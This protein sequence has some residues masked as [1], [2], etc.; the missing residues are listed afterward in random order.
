MEMIPYF[1]QKTIIVSSLLKTVRM[2]D[3]KKHF[4]FC[5]I[6]KKISKKIDLTFALGVA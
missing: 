4:E 5:K 6:M 2:D 1:Y 3:I